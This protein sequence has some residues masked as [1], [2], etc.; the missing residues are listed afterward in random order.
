MYMYNVYIMVCLCVYMAHVLYIWDM[1]VCVC[2]CV[3]VYG[4]CT[5]S[6]AVFSWSTVAVWSIK[7]VYSFIKYYSCTIAWHESIGFLS[8][9]LW[10][11]YLAHSWSTCEYYH[12][13][14]WPISS[15]YLVFYNLFTTIAF[16]ISCF[17]P[18]YY[19]QI[20]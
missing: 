5:I 8:W 12:L 7:P 9:L 16:G 1:L 6:L 4:M 11:L 18:L 15:Q 3:H 13:P 10:I 17:H 2:V 20:L 19:Y 14:L